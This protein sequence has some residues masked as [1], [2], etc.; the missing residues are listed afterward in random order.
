[1]GYSSDKGVGM[2]P[3]SDAPMIGDDALRLLARV[4]RRL[5]LVP[6]AE[7]VAKL[8]LVVLGSFILIAFLDWLVRFPAIVRLGFLC[9]GSIWAWV[10]A[11]RHVCRPVFAPVPLDQLALS[12]N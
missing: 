3:G 7:A 12:L 10:W 4:R 8:I 5:R 2:K 11:Y 1:M 9:A 6:A